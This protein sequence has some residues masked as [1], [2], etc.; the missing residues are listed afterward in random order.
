[1]MS[2]AASRT[3]AVPV[4]A[5][6]LYEDGWLFRGPRQALVDVGGLA[7]RASKGPRVLPERACSRSRTP[8]LFSD[9]PHRP[10]CLH[11]PPRL[12]GLDEFVTAAGTSLPLRVGNRDFR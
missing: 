11:P 6:E 8:R 5:P 4:H 2:L 9:R 12:L 1:M 3:R 7:R 10:R